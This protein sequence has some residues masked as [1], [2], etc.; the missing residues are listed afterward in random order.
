MNG[1]TVEDAKEAMRLA[2]NKLPIKTKFMIK[3]DMAEDA[4]T[5]TDSG[6]EQA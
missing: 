2:S 5:E 1:V 3:A 4:E 6:E